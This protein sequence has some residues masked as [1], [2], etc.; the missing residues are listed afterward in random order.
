M[1]ST[2]LGTNGFNSTGLTSSVDTTPS[3]L[4]SRHVAC[5][6]LLRL[7]H[8]SSTS[9]SDAQ[10]AGTLSRKPSAIPR[11]A[12]REPSRTAQALDLERVESISSTTTIRRASAS[13]NSSLLSTR[14]QVSRCS[15]CVLAYQH[16][17]PRFPTSSCRSCSSHSSSISRR[18][19]LD[20]RP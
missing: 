17:K 2:I 7:P 11:E 10:Q 20:L 12:Y 14:A 15:A 6:R 8:D 19:P 16:R 4:C 1:K 5:S 18:M 13:P 9:L 3:S